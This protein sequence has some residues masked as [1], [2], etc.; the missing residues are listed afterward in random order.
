MYLIEILNVSNLK[1]NWNIITK[2][3]YCTLRYSILP[4]SSNSPSS[5]QPFSVTITSGLLYSFLIQLKI[6]K[7]TF[8]RKEIN[9]TEITNFSK[10]LNPFGTEYNQN[11]LA[12]GHELL[13]L[14]Y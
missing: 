8:H 10:S 4:L 2:F 9:P 7:I 12:C 1:L 13:M 5:D 3:I 14:G 6:Q 11:D